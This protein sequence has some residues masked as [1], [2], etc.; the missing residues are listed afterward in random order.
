MENDGKIKRVCSYNELSKQELEDIFYDGDAKSEQNLVAWFAG[1]SHST[2]DTKTS[3]K[4]KRGS[5]RDSKSGES[6]KKDKDT[7]GLMEKE[8]RQ[9]GFV[10]LSVYKWFVRS[11]GVG[12]MVGMAVVIFVARAV[13]ASASFYLS[14]WGGI[15][16]DA[17]AEG[18]EISEERNLK[19]LN[20]YACIVVRSPFF[21]FCFL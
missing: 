9:V 11:G 4:A 3:T 13:N 8:D 16:A 5:R 1:S 19:Y 17:Q 10:P 7:S 20:N 15:N 12:Y 18:S 6:E 14:Y 21:F 2:A